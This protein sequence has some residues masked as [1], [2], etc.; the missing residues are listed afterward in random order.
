MEESVRLLPRAVQIN[1]LAEFWIRDYRANRYLQHLS[2]TDLDERIADIASN[3]M[4]LG[5]D[6]KYRPRFRVR[7]DHTYKIYAP[8]RNLDF[9]RLATDAW[10]EMRLRG[11]NTRLSL[12]AR[13]VQLAKRLPDESWCKR[14]DWISKSRLSLDKY[15]RPRMLFKF[16]RIQWNEEFIHTG[17]IHISPAS[18]YN[19]TAAINAIRDDELRFEWY[20]EYLARRVLEVQDYFCLCLSSEYDYRLFVD[21]RYDSCVA[22]QNPSEFSRRLRQAI[23]KHNEEHPDYGISRLIECPIIYVDPFAVVSPQDGMEV[24]FCKHFRF[25]YQT[26]FRF[27]L[28]PAVHR[29]LQPFFLS[30]GGITDIAEMVQAPEIPS[31]PP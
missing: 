10:E 7:K 9:L 8:I 24:H 17:Q 25:S 14:A 6:G 13:L 23:F 18:H 27:V 21:F 30:L 31:S 20:D 28:M 11:L 1:S 4:A 15:E 5:D 3:M 29:K 12:E 19:D 16:S 2:K 22:I 26:E